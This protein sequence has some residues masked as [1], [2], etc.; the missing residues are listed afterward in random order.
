MS[1]GDVCGLDAAIAQLGEWVR[2]VAPELDRQRKAAIARNQGALEDGTRLL[3]GFGGILKP[4]TVAS[5][6]TPV[7]SL[8]ALVN[9]SYDAA[10]M[11]AAGQLVRPAADRARGEIRGQ[12]QEGIASL[13]SL[14]ASPGWGG[15]A[16]SR[17][18]WLEQNEG[19]VERAASDMSSPELLARFAREYPR[20]RLEIALAAAFAALYDRGD[21]AGAAKTLEDLGPGVR[22]ASASLNYSLSY[23]YWWQGQS[24][25]EGDRDGL[26]ARAK[27]AYDAGKALRV[28]LAGMGAGLFAPTFVEEMSRR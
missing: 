22:A 1:K 18:Q 17:R 9:G 14:R 5:L 27:A 20:A 7:D 8:A 25:R 12:I 23:F 3:A 16:A 13:R 15:V 6:K 26:M 24:A 2:T 4:E 11:D 10:A 19:A 28:D 21:A